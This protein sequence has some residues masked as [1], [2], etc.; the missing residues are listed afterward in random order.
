MT[1]GRK[2]APFRSSQ[3]PQL[4]FYSSRAPLSLY[5]WDVNKK[6]IHFLVEKH[7]IYSHQPAS[8]SWAFVLLI[9]PVGSHCSGML[10]HRTATRPGNML[11]VNQ[12][13]PEELL[14]ADEAVF[15]PLLAG[16]MSVSC[17]CFCLR[18]H[19][20]YKFNWSWINQD[21]GFVL[22][23]PWRVPCPCQWC[24][25]IPEEALW[26][27]DPLRPHLCLPHTGEINKP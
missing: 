22:K 4:L 5:P 25:Y 7:E 3:V 17:F 18:W 1:R 11:S 23:D 21:F 19:I 24:Q 16:Q 12:E 14:Q 8:Q 20:R 9:A 2:T 27:C 15:C 10:P 13:I 6:Y 26:A